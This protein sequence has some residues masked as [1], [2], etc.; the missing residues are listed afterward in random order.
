MILIICLSFIFDNIISLFI[1]QN[2]IFFPLFS[3]LSLLIIFS[4]NLKKHNYFLLSFGIGFLYDLLF[5]DTLF[6]NSGIFLLLSLGIYFIFKKINYN[7]FNI[8]L[9]SIL[10]II[11]YRVITYILFLL[12]FSISFNIFTL[13][14]G[15]YSSI[16][17]NIV[18]VSLLYFIRNK[19]LNGS[20]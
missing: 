18:Y 14:K 5:T 3:L 17:I 6:V 7:F 19:R 8:I 4:Y 11:L 1:N 10:L 9:V 15:I 20:K 16:I 12:N 13:L 2:C